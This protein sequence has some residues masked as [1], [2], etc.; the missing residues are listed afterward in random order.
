MSGCLGLGWGGGW[1]VTANGYKI[2]FRDDKNVLKLDYGGKTVKLYT[3]RGEI[4]G[5]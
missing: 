3:L 5:M 2:S 4:Y 1:R